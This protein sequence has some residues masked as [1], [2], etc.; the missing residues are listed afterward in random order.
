MGY[1]GLP[2]VSIKLTFTRIFYL[3]L[4]P[5][6]SNDIMVVRMQYWFS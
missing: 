6:I 5:G 3:S 1:F 2:P 4:Y